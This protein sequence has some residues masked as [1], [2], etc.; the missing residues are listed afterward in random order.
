MF[1]AVV[2]NDK[3]RAARGRSDHE[4][5]LEVFVLCFVNISGTFS[6]PPDY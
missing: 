4:L 2:D 3:G 6:C 1:K 5:A